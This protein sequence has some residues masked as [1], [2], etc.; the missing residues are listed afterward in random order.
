MGLV[1]QEISKEIRKAALA[2]LIAHTTSKALMTKKAALV[3]QE[4]ASVVQVIS[5]KVKKAVSAVQEE[6]ITQEGQEG[7]FGGPSRGRQG[8]FGGPKRPTARR[9]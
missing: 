2:T 7:S 3:V 8:G 4:A 9:L 1:V 5:R 6:D